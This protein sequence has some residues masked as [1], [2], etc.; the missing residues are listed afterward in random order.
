MFCSP[1][2]LVLVNSRYRPEFTSLTSIFHLL[3][4]PVLSGWMAN[5]LCYTAV[6]V[7]VLTRKQMHQ[8]LI[9]E[10]GEL[11]QLLIWASNSNK[12]GKYKAS[13]QTIIIKKK[14][15]RIK[16]L[17]QCY[18]Q[19]QIG[20]IVLNNVYHIKFR[21]ICIAHS[22][23]ELSLLLTER[24]RW[25]RILKLISFHGLDTSCHTRLLR[26]PSNLALLGSSSPL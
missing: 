2:V 7:T 25:E 20:R 23:L 13:L 3:P 15:K 16:K 14:N 9:S 17:E 4:W 26:A 6:V 12:S 24:F 8:H 5:W 11:Q 22:F 10:L 21:L 19:P 18:L 1:Y